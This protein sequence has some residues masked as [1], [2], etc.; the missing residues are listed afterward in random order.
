MTFA[1][2]KDHPLRVSVGRILEIQSKAEMADPVVADNEQ[3]AFAR[4]KTFAIVQS[5][6]AL[7]QAT[8]A[9][10][11][12]SQAMAQ[13]H[14][15]IQAPLNELNSYLSNKNPG[16]I[17]NA[18]TQLEQSVLPLLWAFAPQVQ[19][20]PQP[21]LSELL[22][23]QAASAAQAVHQLVIQRDEL[24][25]KLQNEVSRADALSTRLDDMVEGA[26]KERAES[27]AA[28]A[29]LEKAFAEKEIERATA[30]EASLTKFRENF[31][32]LEGKSKKDSEA[33]IAALEDQ[34]SKAAQIVQV[35]GN[36]GVTGNYQQIANTEAKQANFWRWATVLVFAAGITVAGATFIKFWNQPFSVENTWSVVIRLLYAIAITAPAWYTARESARHRTNA[37]RARQTELEL[38]SIGPFIELMPEERKV[39]IREELT[40]VYFGKQVEAHEVKTSLDVTVM[41]DLAIELAKV[42]RK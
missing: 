41:K 23:Q 17:V 37:D 36:I 42:L 1:A 33:L 22:E 30:F 31:G 16:H 38:A 20:L 15:H 12:S 35:V 11:A 18:A 13:I 19:A 32:L 3:Y 40:K 24:A 14:A 10:L 8:P 26:T 7:L 28:V 29:K 27:A 25:I 5:I 9:T 6:Q 39:A 4:D 34:K 21:N 2:Y